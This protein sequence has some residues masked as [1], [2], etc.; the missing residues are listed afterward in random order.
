MYINY[1][2]LEY[3]DGF[4]WNHPQKFSA[5]LKSFVLFVGGSALRILT[6]SAL[7]YAG[8]TDR[9]FKPCNSQSMLGL[10]PS[11]P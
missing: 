5:V 6:A 8:K 1:L 3:W 2:P 4:C 10:H 9:S 11:V 7:Q